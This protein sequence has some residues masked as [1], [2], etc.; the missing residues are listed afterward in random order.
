MHVDPSN[1]VLATTTF[2]GDQEGMDW[3]SGTVMPVAW[4]RR[5]GKARVF[6]AS[7]GH[8]A[9]DFEVAGTKE[10]MTRGMLWSSR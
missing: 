7:F 9:S 6:Y 2:K 1:E 5:F 3:I 8:V 10:I 4:K